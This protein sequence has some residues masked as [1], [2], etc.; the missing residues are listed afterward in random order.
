MLTACIQLCSGTSID[1]NIQAVDALVRTAYKDGARFISTP[2]N[3]HFMGGGTK[4]LFA[5]ISAEEDCHAVAHFRALAKE[6][7]IDL[8]IGSLAIKLSESKAANRS[9]LFGTDGAIKARY[10]KIHLFDVD[11]NEREVWRE[12]HNYRAGDRPVLA[13]VDGLDLGLS[14]CYDVRFAALYKYYAK[15][16]AHIMSVPAAFTAVTGE[17]HWEVL[18]RARAIENS[19]YVIAP[20][21][22]GVHEDGRMTWGRSM[23]IDPW[24]V[25]IAQLNHDRPG[26]CLADIDIAL[27]NNIRAK[28]PAWRQNTVLGA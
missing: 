20:A 9:F 15:H 4:A 3:T 28:I 1:T 21:Q 10:D 19:A 11:I 14:I 16:G 12:S 27:V 5:S 7:A 18:L 24:G 8:L 13:N 17:A 6:L 23:I 22:G 26:Y 2:E 25:V